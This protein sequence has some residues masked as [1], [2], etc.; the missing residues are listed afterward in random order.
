MRGAV[1]S[2]EKYYGASGHS[3]ASMRGSM[4]GV[5]DASGFS[6][7]WEPDGGMLSRQPGKT[8]FFT[9]D[10]ERQVV[11]QELPRKNKTVNTKVGFDIDSESNFHWLCDGQPIDE[12]EA[13]RK[14]LEP[15]LFADRSHYS[16]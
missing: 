7:S 5:I 16:C 11:V 9:L 6:L 10:Y 14:L 12:E 2:F 15:I 3:D 1:D 8:W 4:K 13:S